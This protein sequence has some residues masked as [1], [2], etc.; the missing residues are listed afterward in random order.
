MFTP[1]YITLSSKKFLDDVV[2]SW[3]D[4]PT[5]KDYLNQISAPSTSSLPP[6]EVTDPVRIKIEPP[7][8][9]TPLV[10][11]EPQVP[12]LP[13]TV[14][15]R[16]LNEAGK[17]VFEILSDSEPDVDGRDS[18]I[19][20]V[21]ALR[22]SSR[23]SSVISSSYVNPGGSDS[24]GL[25]AAGQD[26]E[27]SAMSDA[28][29]L[30]ESDTGWQDDGTS[31]VRVGT[32][33]PTR[34]M[35]VEQMEYRTGPALLYPIHRIPTDIVVD[36]SDEKH[37][38]RDSGTGELISL[39]SI[40]FNSVRVRGEVEF[41]SDFFWT[42]AGAICSGREPV[43]CKR[44][45]GECRGVHAC[46]QLDRALRDVVRFQL[47]PTSRDA[48]IAAQQ[49][50]RRRDGNSHEERA[51]P[52]LGSS[53]GHD[54][55]I[56]CTG[57]KPNWQDHHLYKMIPDNVDANLIARGLAGQALSDDPAKDTP[58]CSA[59]IPP[60][61]GL[62]KKYCS[63][64][65]IVNG[66]QVRGQIQNYACDATRNM[67]IPKDP[68]IRK[69]LIIHGPTP[70]NHPMPMLTK[71]TFEIK[72][73]YRSIIA[74]SGVLGATVSKI[75]NAQSTK[76]LL[77]GKTPAAFAPALY[78][79]RLKQDMVRAAKLE[80]YRNGL[81]VDAILPMY[82]AELVKPL[83]ERYISGQS[84]KKASQIFFFSFLL[85]SCAEAH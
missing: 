76:L 15:V 29:D 24:E 25:D 85:F 66:V 83:P 1:A 60:R 28:T 34:R 17:E 12:D 77:N 43:E 71:A 42:T 46:D 54:H 41:N 75:D 4:V 68:S 70:H 51:V 8:A 23:A 18:D 32:F 58:P 14:K 39:S 50:T 19:E 38:F 35:T 22:P 69:V 49:D 74:A 6:P 63:H 31:L 55:F 81:G 48:V 30:A 45:G 11:M 72:D 57:W 56:G 26:L 7:S 59:M 16:T 36:L 20:V 84:K 73:T 62:R 13:I 79:N 10:K 21:D 5:L 53:R 80:K 37:W 33:R 61:T 9:P 65:H 78:D 40:I 3:V 47:D 82:Y 27:S 67:W 2:Q 52:C 44:I 64:A